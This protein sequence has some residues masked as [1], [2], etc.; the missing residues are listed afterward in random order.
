MT[1]A[2]VGRAFRPGRMDVGRTFR[3]G[4]S[5]GAKAPAC[6]LLAAATLTAQTPQPLPQMVAAE[7]AFA[8]ATAEIGVRD[9][10]L[11]FFADDAVQ[12][13]AGESGRE[14]QLVSARQGL[15]AR[16]PVKLPLAAVLMWNPHTGH[17]SGD[18]QMG[19]LTGPYVVMD[20]VSRQPVGQGAYFSVW[21]RQQDGTWKVW[22]DEG[23][24]LPSIWTG[25]SEFQAAPEPDVAR[26][27]NP[28]E[29][30]DA[31]EAS[32]ATSRAAWGERLAEHVRVHRNG[33]LPIAGRAAAL[34]G[35]ESARSAIAWTVVRV[36]VAGSGDLAVAVGGY[37]ATTT[38]GAEHGTWARVWKR[39][40]KGT[41]RI[42]FETSRA[43]R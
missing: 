41:W 36:E 31:A 35:D 26:E 12:I 4:V 3:S 42:V 27:A 24:E 2:R 10:F 19:W 1:G 16:P 34:E 14:M 11:T 39:D 40:V 37:D 23:I 18:G 7:R 6:V 32:L 17:V 22:L 8:A 20:S 15:I 38:A 43:A 9:G 13:A 29:T 21:K 5:A 25:A 28:R 33:R 30:A